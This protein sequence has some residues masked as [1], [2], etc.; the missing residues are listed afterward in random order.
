MSR[1]LLAACIILK[2]LY[3]KGSKL[4]AHSSQLIAHSY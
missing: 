1:E 2:T 4:T 3:Y